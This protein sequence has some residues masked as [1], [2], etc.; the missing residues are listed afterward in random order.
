M[1]DMV[2]RPAFADID[3]ERAVILEEIAM[4]EDDPQEKVFDLLGRAVFGEHP[5][6]R[7][8]IGYAP[9]IANTP[10]S[11]IAAF[12][13][14]SYT[15]ANVVIAATGAIEH[16]RLV[17]LAA[18]RIPH[19]AAAAADNGSPTSPATNSAQ[20]LFERK[21]TEQYHVCLGGPGLSRHDERR[22]ALRVL[23]TIWGGTTSSRLFQEVRERRG[24][25]Y[26]V[27]SFTSAYQDIGQV[28]IYV[29]TRPDN[30]TEAV[31]VISAE[32]TRLRQEPA[33]AE[34]LHRAKENL[35]GRVVLS[36]ESTGARMNRLGSEILAEA[37]LLSLDEVVDRI[38]AVTLEDLHALVAELWAP[39]SLSS[40]GIGPDESQFDEAL[41]EL[42]AAGVA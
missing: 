13:A 37:P 33:T 39:E 20:R 36:L 41:A 25:A 32:L 35:K 40:A 12:H 21:D 18:E 6:G 22:F 26:A 27:Y 24:L 31:K 7:A 1:A 10:V 28:G 23:D 38:D 34:E 17:E 16:E 4:Y 15:P 2:F 9:V 3:A 8:I 11:E 5:L 14:N 29:G 30:L 42:A 19:Q